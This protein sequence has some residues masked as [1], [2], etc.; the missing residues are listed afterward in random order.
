MRTSGAATESRMTVAVCLVALLIL[1]VLAG[2]PAEFMGSC[3]RFLRGVAESAHDAW[4][5]A[6][7]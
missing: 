3:E 6:G 5:K 4:V 7:R 1:V 2:G